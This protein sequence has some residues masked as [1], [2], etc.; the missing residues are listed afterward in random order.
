[1][2]WGDNRDL[3]TAQAKVEMLENENAYLRRQVDSLQEALMSKL[4]PLAYMELK[5]A[6]TDEGSGEPPSN[7]AIEQYK[8]DMKALNRYAE[9]IEK[10]FFADADD[11]IDKLTQAT[12]GPKIG[13]KSIH[14]NS[15]S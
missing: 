7:E 1:M 10:P 5:A 6:Q 4:A 12:G 2:A 3:A 13:K 15:E 8:R 11:M 9:D 14:G